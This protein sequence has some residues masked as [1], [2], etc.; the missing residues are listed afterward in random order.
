MQYVVINEDE[1]N[2]SAQQYAGP[3]FPTR[4]AAEAARRAAK[5][6]VVGITDTGKFVALD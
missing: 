3:L 4:E 2:A 1:V 6:Y 5:D